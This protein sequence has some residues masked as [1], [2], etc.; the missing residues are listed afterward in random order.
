[1]AA[2]FGRENTP[3]SLD[4]LADQYR[5]RKMMAVLMNSTDVTTSGITPLPN[6]RVAAAVRKHP[7]AFSGFG[8]ID[9]HQGKIALDETRRMH[10]A[11]G[12]RGIVERNP[13]PEAFYPT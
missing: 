10:E 3:V 7:D 8:A 1:M 6:A 4:D 13:R 9:P 5:A 2:Y 11:L 12:L